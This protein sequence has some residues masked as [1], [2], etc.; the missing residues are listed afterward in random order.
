MS[1]KK[2]KY[3]YGVEGVCESCIQ[4]HQ[5]QTSM[6]L[7]HVTI[8]KDHIDCFQYLINEIG[9]YELIIKYKRYAY[10]KQLL[11]H[12]YRILWLDGIPNENIIIPFIEIS[13]KSK[14]PKDDNGD[15][16]WII[17][18]FTLGKNECSLL[19]K[20]IHSGWS[21]KQIEDDDHKDVLEYIKTIKKKEKTEFPL[22]KTLKCLSCKTSIDINRLDE[23]S[24]FCRCGA[25][26]CIECEQNCKW[27]GP[28]FHIAC[29]ECS[30]Q[31]PNC[32][33]YHCYECCAKRICD[34]CSKVC[35]QWCLTE[36]EDRYYCKKCFKKL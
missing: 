1:D 10:L 3:P 22:I 7:Q 26:Y 35:C 36:K 30:K 2:R 32:K 27:C 6:T 14:P 23:L 15:L 33:Q 31:C 21:T 8:L 9:C 19:K 34:N 17:C 25:I 16:I 28:C 11:L 24:Y 29:E 12:E 20:A 5:N 4:Y 13:C 18:R